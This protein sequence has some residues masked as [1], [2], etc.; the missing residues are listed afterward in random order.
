MNENEER[1][2]ERE[3]EQRRISAVVSPGAPPASVAWPSSFTTLSPAERGGS[4]PLS[5]AQGK[6]YR[7]AGRR[8]RGIGPE[9]P[10]LD[11]QHPKRQIGKRNGIAREGIVGCDLQG[12]SLAR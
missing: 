11:A 5:A 7:N 1:E 6:T 9:Q 8:I 4:G 10:L 2:R 12:K 3:R